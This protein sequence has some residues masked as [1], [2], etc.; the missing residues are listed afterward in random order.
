MI[1]TSEHAQILLV[2]KLLNGAG[3]WCGET[4]IQK[5]YFLLQEL[6]VLPLAKTFVLHHYGPY[7]FDLR[8]QVVELQVA[9]FLRLS[10]QAPYGP[11]LL[12]SDAGESFLNRNLSSFAPYLKNIENIIRKVGTKGV[13]ELERLSTALFLINRRTSLKDAEKVA[14]ELTKVKPHITHT[15]AIEAVREA[16]GWKLNGSHV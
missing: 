7:S 6:N 13:S 15:L 1:L 5:T 9:N 12:V 16:Q 14:E 8:E 3:S 4:H 11:R 2:A 10:I